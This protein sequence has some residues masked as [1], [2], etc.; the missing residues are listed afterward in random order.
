MQVDYF[1]SKYVLSTENGCVMINEKNIASA[2]IYKKWGNLVVKHG[3]NTHEFN[4]IGQGVCDIIKLMKQ[5][6]ED[7]DKKQLSNKRK[8]EPT[9]NDDLN[10]KIT[11]VVKTTQNSTIKGNNNNKINEKEYVFKD[12]IVKVVRNIMQSN[13]HKETKKETLMSIV[14]LINEGCGDQFKRFS[15]EFI[16][17]PLRATNQKQKMYESLFK[18]TNTT[19][20]HD[21]IKK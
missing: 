15:E 16:L 14:N 10:D 4:N 8:R 13:I 18:N 3:S 5:A 7:Y 6:K 20:K 12:E 11:K 19:N 21:Q 1:D 9:V 2:T 17:N